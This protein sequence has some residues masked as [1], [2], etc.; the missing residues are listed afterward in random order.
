MVPD[1]GARRL[2]VLGGWLLLFVGAT[3]VLGWALADLTLLQPVSSF[4]RSP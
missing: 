4:P 3:S 1:A 2:S